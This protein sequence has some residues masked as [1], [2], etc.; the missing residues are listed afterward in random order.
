MDYYYKRLYE[1]NIN[2]SIENDEYKNS[3]KKIKTNNEVINAPFGSSGDVKCV[4]N[5]IYFYCDVNI[6]NVYKLIE[7]INT[8]NKNFKTLKSS[9]PYV[10]ME[11][12]PIY[13]HINSYGGGVYAALTAI[14]VIQ[15]SKIPIYT[16]VEGTAASAATIMSVVGRKR[17]IRPNAHMLIHQIRSWVTGK[18]NEI[19]DEYTNLT[20]LTKKIKNIYIKNTNLKDL[21]NLL[22]HD[23]WWDADKC[24]EVGLVDKLY[25]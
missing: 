19:E 9:N 24:L 2:N 23:L 11:H 1:Y 5:H 12:D 22:S 15:S 18:M 16:I 6:D 13:L 7:H 3:S 17:Y 14:D 21:D 20:N 25:N 4:D 8:I 10:Y